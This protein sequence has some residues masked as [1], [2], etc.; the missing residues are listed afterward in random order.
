MNE[1]L[2]KLYSDKWELLKSKASKISGIKSAHPLLIKVSKEYER[3]D[4]KVMIVGQETDGWHGVFGGSGSKTIEYLMNDYE[5]FLGGDKEHSHPDKEFFKKRLK[6]KTRRPFFSKRNFSF[7]ESKLKEYFS[8]KSVECVWN[9][10]SK[11]G[12]EGSP[13][14]K[15]GKVT[16]NLR[17]LEERFFDVWLEEFRILK[18]CIIIFTTGSRDG[19]IKHHFDKENEECKFI[20]KL[21]FDDG[22]V[23]AASSNLLAEVEIP[24]FEHICAVRVQHPNRRALSND[25]VLSVIKSC[26]KRKNP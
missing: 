5:A 21:C 20:P 18:P 6:K 14:E 26:W 17:D 1:A 16:S 9:N 24:G 12:K 3:A 11:I 2:E 13:K 19:F 15:R 22:K 25:I 4:V 23:L 8:D 7:F 10:I